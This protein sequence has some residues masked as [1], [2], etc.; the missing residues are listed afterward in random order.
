MDS[1]GE[2]PCRNQTRIIACQ[3]YLELICFLCSS[4][5]LVF[6]SCQVTPESQNDFGSYNC[7]A[8]NEMGTE[9]K[10]FLLIQAGSLSLRDPLAEAG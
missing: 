6:P 4:D 1:S 10:E 5:F 9:S 7:T 2:S 8:S 3:V